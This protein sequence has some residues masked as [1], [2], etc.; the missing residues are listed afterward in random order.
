MMTGSINFDEQFV[1]RSECGVDAPD[2]SFHFG[3]QNCS[4]W[5]KRPQFAAEHRHC[6]MHFINRNVAI[7]T[8]PSRPIVEKTGG[9]D[10]QM[11]A[12]LTGFAGH[13]REML[14]M[15]DRGIPAYYA[16]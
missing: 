16:Q 6:G 15:S 13:L 14:D 3:E 7:A 2:R 10:C 1:K 8:A 5:I 9:G 12:V 4:R 11:Y